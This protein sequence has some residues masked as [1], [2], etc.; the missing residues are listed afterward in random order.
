MVHDKQRF[1]VGSG[2]ASEGHVPGQFFLLKRGE[3]LAIRHL[4]PKERMK[5]F[6]RFSYGTRFGPAAITPVFAA[7]HARHCAGLAHTSRAAILTVPHDLSALDRVVEF[8]E[9]ELAAD[10]PGNARRA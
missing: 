8:V 7:R 6:L 2:F 9:A 1:L 10:A 5:A 4:D 3:E